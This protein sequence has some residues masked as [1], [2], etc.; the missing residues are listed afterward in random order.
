[1]KRISSIVRRGRK[2]PVDVDVVN[3]KL[4]AKV[5]ATY[6]ILDQK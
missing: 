5:I 1:M 3:N 2:V 4:V 6:I